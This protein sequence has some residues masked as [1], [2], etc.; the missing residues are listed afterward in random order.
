MT[1]KATTEPPLPPLQLYGA[2]DGESAIGFRRS[3]FPIVHVIAKAAGGAKFTVDDH[4]TTCEICREH[5]VT[6]DA[7]F[8]WYQSQLS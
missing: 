1:A 4:F 7:F 5:G 2:L 6:Q 8:A 3:D